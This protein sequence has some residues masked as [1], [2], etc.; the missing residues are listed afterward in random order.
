MIAV[1]AREQQLVQL[2]QQQLR[3]QRQ[4]QL[5]Q[6]QSG[7]RRSHGSRTGDGGGGGGGGELAGGPSLFR[8]PL[9][10]RELLRHEPGALER[11]QACL[12]AGEVRVGGVSTALFWC[13]FPSSVQRRR[14]GWC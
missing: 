7:Q 9:L 5:Q 11:L 3:Q 12:E 10:L 13:L 6:Q 2:Q 1:E 4:R 8:V 14:M